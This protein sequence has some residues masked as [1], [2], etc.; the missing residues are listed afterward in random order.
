MLGH[1]LLDGTDPRAMKRVEPARDDQA[2]AGDGPP[3][4]HVPEDQ[5]AE[6]RRKDEQQIGEGL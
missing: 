1:A 4:G 3:V 6:Q 5:P 2:G